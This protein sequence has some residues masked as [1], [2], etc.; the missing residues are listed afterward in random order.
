MTSARLQAALEGQISAGASGA[1]AR[2]ESPLAGLVWAGSAGRL[3][4][5]ESRRLRPDDPFRVATVTKSVTATAAVRL[6]QEDRLALD[7]PLGDQLGS[8]LLERWRSLE[9]LPHTTPR[10]L[11][12]HTSGL[13]DYFQ[14]EGFLARVR[15]EPSRAW[16]PVEFVDHVA[17]HCTPR[18]PPGEGFSY[19]DTG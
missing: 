4:R 1:L 2:V 7:E 15:Q 10:Q 6:A 17:A 8:K 13:P 9:A 19:S 14:E 16:Q 18:F 5:G 11:L 3:A 12:A